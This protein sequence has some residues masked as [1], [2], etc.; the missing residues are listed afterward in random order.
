MSRLVFAVVFLLMLLAGFFAVLQHCTPEPTPPVVLPAPAAGETPE[1]IAERKRLFIA[2]LLP[3]IQHENRRLLRE[4][5]RLSRIERDLSNEDDISRDDFDWLKQLATEYALDP[6]ARRNPEFFRSMRARIDELPASLII[7]QAALES[8]WGR[9]E[10]SRDSNN[11]F[12]HYCFDKGCGTPAPGPGDL[13]K[14]DSLQDS[15]AAYMHNLNSH[16]AYAALRRQRA[17]LHAT[18]K[19]VTGT[20]LADGLQRYSEHGDAYV[21]DV[22]Q[23]IRDNALDALADH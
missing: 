8:G 13:R 9:A 2:L 15:V 16:P 7:A 10:I 23:M 6:A 4:R 5:E 20:I 18:D 22:K 17:Q 1:Q 3:I 12:G 19:T 11:Y 21:A 14:F